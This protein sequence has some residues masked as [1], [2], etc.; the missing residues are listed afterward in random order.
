MTRCRT[1][2]SLPR[3]DRCQA[4]RIKSAIPEHRGQQHASGAG[5][6]RGLQIG[7]VADAA[8][9]ME[10]VTRCAAAQVCQA[11]Q[12][13]ATAAAHPLQIHQ[14]Q[15]P[16][17]VRGGLLQGIRAQGF[18]AAPVQRQHRMLSF[19]ECGPER[20]KTGKGLAA[21]HRSH[22]LRCAQGS[23]V[24]PDGTGPVAGQ[25]RNQ[26]PLVTDAGDRVQIRQIKRLEGM[27]LAQRGQHVGRFAVAN[28]RAVERPIVL[29][30]PAGGAHH[31]TAHQV[32]RRNDLEGG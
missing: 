25:F 18:V 32:H 9:K 17:P 3:A 27:Q 13:R 23:G 10:A 30:S 12:I 4:I 19:G 28:Q 2:V 29:A 1:S 20:S 22:T 24:Q 5:F 16:G 8:G 14:E 11:R 7:M 31:P 6:A 26:L 15:V 21:Q